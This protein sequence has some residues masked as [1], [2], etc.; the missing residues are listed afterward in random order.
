MRHSGVQ[1]T[2]TV[3]HTLEK[4]YIQQHRSFLEEW[5][6]IRRKFCNWERVRW[7][8]VGY[9]EDRLAEFMRLVEI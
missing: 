6:K 3:P 5:F 1:S 8:E 7:Q 4:G 9:I 2:L